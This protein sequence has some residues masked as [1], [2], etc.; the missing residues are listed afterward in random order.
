MFKRFGISAVVLLLIIS[1]SSISV[2]QE[3]AILVLD[4]SGSMWGQINGK[5]NIGIAREVI[6]GVVKDWNRKNDIGL[7]AYGHRSKGDCKDIQQ[8]IPVGKLN[9]AAFNRAVKGLNP[10]GKTPLTDAVRIAAMKLRYTEDKA[11]VILVSDGK[12]TCG[13]DPCAVAAELEKTGV[14]FTTHVIGFDVSDRKGIGQLKCLARNTGGSY[15]TARD[16]AGLKKA[17]K[18][19]VKQVAAPVVVPKPKPKPKPKVDPNAP[20]NVRVQAIAAEG[21]KPLGIT[22][23]GAYREETDQFGKPKRIKVTNSGYT[24][25]AKFSVKPGEYLFMPKMERK[26]RGSNN[27]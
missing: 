3:Q 24:G 26:N 18:T 16:A 22:W 8:L 17:L 7:I 6:S 21:G 25:E 2:A 4:A 5:S 1:I 11:T 10:R 12:E 15:M 23:F 19:A 27:Y 9:V 20:V 14:D 13:A